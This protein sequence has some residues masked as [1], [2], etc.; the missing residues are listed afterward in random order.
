MFALILIVFIW[1]SSMLKTMIW[2]QLYALEKVSSVT[3]YHLSLSGM[4]LR[5]LLLQV[6]RFIHVNVLKV[7]MPSTANGISMNGRWKWPITDHYWKI[8]PTLYYTSFYW[9]L[10]AQKTYGW[11]I[12][13]ITLCRWSGLT[14]CRC[15][16][17]LS[18]IFAWLLQI[19]TTVVCA[20]K[21][22]CT[23]DHC[24]PYGVC[25]STI[26]LVGILKSSNS[27]IRTC[28][29]EM[30]G[31]RRNVGRFVFTSVLVT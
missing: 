26:C 23:D 9:N 3:L 14:I 30:I 11:N 8:V 20:V 27:V 13:G 17:H 16:M 4:K 31:C 24:V 22:Y 19:S 29:T 1:S 21:C 15:V 6:S 5:N 10:W 12:S 28:G 7:L 18:S 25:E 2:H